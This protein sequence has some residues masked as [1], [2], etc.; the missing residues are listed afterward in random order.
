MKKEN[1]E[2]KAVMEQQKARMGEKQRLVHDYKH[3][4]DTLQAEA[5]G[6][7]VSGRQKARREC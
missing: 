6:K 1:K 7:V 3:Q 2:L 4:I 5:R